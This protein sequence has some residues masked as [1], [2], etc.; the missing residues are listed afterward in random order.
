VVVNK[1]RIEGN[2][3]KTAEYQ[4]ARNGVVINALASA[5]PVAREG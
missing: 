3:E 1:E 2:V 5:Q 4:E